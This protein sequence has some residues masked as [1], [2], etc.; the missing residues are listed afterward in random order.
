MRLFG[1]PVNEEETLDFLYR[2]RKL[3][4]GVVISGGEPTLQPDLADFCEKL[5]AFG[6]E[7]KLDTNGARPEV[8]SNLVERGLINYLALDLKADPANY[9]PEIAPKGSGSA[10]IETIHILKNSA[11]PHEYRTTC[12]APFI[13]RESIKAL[14]KAAS[15]QAPLFLQTYRPGEILNPSFMNNFAQP[16]MYDLED[17]RL[18]ASQYLPAIIRG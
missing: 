1:E 13:N 16:T 17:F 3:L 11:L 7:V 4:D 8:V 2:R 12:A 18:V 15:G 14:A 9:P 6:Y 10:I 5:Q